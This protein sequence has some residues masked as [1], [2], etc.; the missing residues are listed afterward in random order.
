VLLLAGVALLSGCDDEDP[1]DPGDDRPFFQGTEDDPQI[2]LVVNSL[3]NT[4]GLFQVGDPAESREVAL[5]ASSAVTPTGI[6]VGPRSLAVPLG[7]AASVALIDAETLRIDRFFLFPSGNATGSAFT[8]DGALLV[9]NL[10]E[11]QVGRVAPDQESDDITQVVSVT[12]APTDI[13][14]V[15]E[16]AL[17]VSGNLD[18]SFA[19]L[20]EGVVTALN[21]TTLEILGTVSTGGQNPSAGAVGPDGL[22]YV[23]NT[24]DF[25]NPATLAI[26]DPVT[27]ERIDVI[28]DAG[29]G[30]GAISVDEDGLAYISGFFL[31]TIVF[32]T[33]TRSWVRD[34]DDPVCAPLDG[35][36]CRG[37]FD[38]VAAEDG[39]LYQT[40]FGSPTEGLSPYVFVY[41]PGTFALADSIAT[42]Q[43]P[44]AARIAMFEP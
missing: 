42:G 8:E 43:G 2:G 21:P 3:D 26:I 31:G 35:G 27:M 14:I 7:N 13:E 6:A 34:S 17:V 20:G 10:L 38:A 39:R 33:V 12:P 29:V 4:L 19:P 18:E 25:V 30:A 36:G 11:D 41:E 37:A 23:V 5:G 24:G 15:G 28:E 32:D 1:V 9:A 44:A 22:L 16:R 40:F